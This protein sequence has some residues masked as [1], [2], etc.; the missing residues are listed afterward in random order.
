MLIFF[1]VICFLQLIGEAIVYM[2]EIPIPGPVIGMILLLVSLI[3]KKGVP[4]SFNTAANGLLRYLALLFVPAGVG[5]TLH[6]HL[7]S[8]EWFA[9]SASVVFATL[10]TIVFSALLMKF[11]VKS[12][13]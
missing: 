5:V 8:K 2:T 3:I 12:D 9:I 4:E 13:G 7:I 1:F 10:L 6:F 11:M